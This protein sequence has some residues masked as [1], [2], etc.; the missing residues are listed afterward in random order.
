MWCQCPKAG[1]QPVTVQID[2][3]PDSSEYVVSI[4]CA[5]CERPWRMEKSAEVSSSEIPMTIVRTVEDEGV[6]YELA[7]RVESE[8]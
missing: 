5:R 6:Y 4:T 3:E 7:P 1:R 8:A 2:G